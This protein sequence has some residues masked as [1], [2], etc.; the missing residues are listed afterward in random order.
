MATP[1]NAVVFGTETV[2]RREMLRAGV[3]LDLLLGALLVG[4]VLLLSRTV[5]PVALP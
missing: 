5:W 3:R 2:S 1:P 4:L